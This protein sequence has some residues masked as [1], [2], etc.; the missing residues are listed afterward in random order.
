MMK[1]LTVFFLLDN[2]RKRKKGRPTMKEEKG[3]KDKKSSDSWN[4]WME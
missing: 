1:N 2:L 4:C 3:W